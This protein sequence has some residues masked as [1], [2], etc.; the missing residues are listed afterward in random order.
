[1]VGLREYILEKFSVAGNE[2]DKIL[3]FDVDDTLIHT[4]AQIGIIKG[5]KIIRHISSTEFNEY[6]L[7]NGENFDYSEFDDPKLLDNEEFTK[8]WNTL[9]R[10]YKKGTHIGIITARSDRDMIFKFFKNKDIEIKKSLIFV[11][12]IV[13][14]SL[15]PF[16]LNSLI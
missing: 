5:G 16:I 12:T 3:L 1:M 2:S 13:T 9:K 7:I 15:S 10:E 4:T 8:Y 11:S 14:K 6:V